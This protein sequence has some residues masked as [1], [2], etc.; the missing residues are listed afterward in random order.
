ML[1]PSIF[2]DSLMD[3]FMDD[4]DR[5]W[6]PTQRALYGKRA[7]NIM[8]T[9][10]HE[11]EDS[12]VVDIDLPGFKKDEI[13]LKLEDGNMTVEAAKAVD[14]DEEDKKSGKFI[15]QERFAGNCRRSFYVGDDVRPEDIS[16]SFENG[17][18]TIRVPKKTAPKEPERRT[19]DIL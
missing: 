9:D 1:F 5:S 13:T 18:L 12:Y 4:F 14:K 10:I 6:Y 17:V 19:I 15:R 7:A 16:A 11:D 3:D 2:G 8:R